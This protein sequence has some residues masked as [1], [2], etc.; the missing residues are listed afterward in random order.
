MTVS[1]GFPAGKGPQVLNGTPVTALTFGNVTT[2]TTSAT[3]ANAALPVDSNGTQ[4]S[5][6]LITVVGGAAWF[7]FCTT[8]SDVAVAKAAN[9]FGISGSQSYVVSVPVGAKFVAAI[10]DSAAGSLNIIGLY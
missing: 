9:T 1:I 5:V 7:N 3:S 10:Q 8:S 4:Y 2:I 6:V